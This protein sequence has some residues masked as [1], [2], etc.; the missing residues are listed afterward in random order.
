MPVKSRI[1]EITVALPGL[2][3]RAVKAGAQI[4]AEKADENLVRG[5]H[6][7]R[8]ELGMAIHV[9]REGA[10]EYAVVAGDDKV[11]WGH[12]VERGTTHSP[13]YPFLVPALEESQ[14]T[15][16]AMVNAA[17]KGIE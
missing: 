9:E 10:A 2:V 5:G 14:D 15:V 7:L 3:S 1:P 4:I 16:V 6:I 13:P 17:T 12:L 8:D 11:F